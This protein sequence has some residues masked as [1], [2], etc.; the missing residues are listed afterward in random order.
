MVWR[1]GSPGVGEQGRAEMGS[2]G[3][4]G[5]PPVSS[6]Q[7]PGKGSYRLNKILVW[8]SAFGFQTPRKR[9]QSG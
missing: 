2:P 8:K 9:K 3:K 1:V 4:L 5:E 7:K 6:T